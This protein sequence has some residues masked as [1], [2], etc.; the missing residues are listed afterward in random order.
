MRARVG[1]PS[2]HA[3]K[4]RAAA[5]SKPLTDALR[6]LAAGDLTVRLPSSDA[7]SDAF[8]AV[9]DRLA[10]TLAGAD[11][12]GSS[13]LDGV[14]VAY[15]D[16]R[17]QQLFVAIVGLGR[18]SELRRQLGS[19]LAG[20]ILAELCR[21]ISEHLPEVRLGR[22]GRTQIEVLFP[23][24]SAAEAEQL[25]DRARIELEAPLEIA[26]QSIDVDVAIGYA[27]VQHGDDVVIENAAMALARAQSGHAKIAGFSA[28]ER[29]AVADRLQLMRDL[30]R[31]LAGDELY[32]HYQ[33][34]FRPRTGEIDSV[35]AL[36]RWTHPQHGQV[37]PDRFIGLAEE[38]GAIAE[39]TRWV[40]QRAIA[41]QKT[42]TDDGWPLPVYVNLSG[43][44]VVDREF[45]RWLLGQARQRPAGAIG[46]EIT[47]TAIISDPRH[48]LANL[49]VL[50]DAGVP[51]AIDDYG[52]GLSS[53]AYLKQLPATELKID[54][55]FVMG[56]TSSHRDP[57][58]VRSTIDLAHALEMEVTAEGVENGPTLALLR[59]MGCDLIQGYFIARPMPLEDLRRFLAKGV[60]VETDFSFMQSLRRR[61]E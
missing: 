60:Q 28:E 21:R 56:L 50:A 4:T 58:L 10:A 24:K 18:F 15:A 34:K 14:S 49:Q 29:R 2:P 31:A 43:R 27:Q 33:P 17:E 6:R 12:A 8:N 51:I 42:L 47:E 40:M 22:V 46:M 11:P 9:A 39:L 25:L 59:T 54:R 7:G 1:D 52:A 35:E 30:H 44:L 5:P 36:I 53:L 61:A 20:Q 57:L 3:A 45:T 38:T 19:E 16:A 26:D 23:A 55:L 32:L 37:P 13:L 41:D 48:A